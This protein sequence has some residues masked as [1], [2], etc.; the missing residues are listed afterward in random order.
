VDGIVGLGGAALLMAISEG[1]VLAGLEVSA[2]DGMDS[3]LPPLAGGGRGGSG[4][5]AHGRWVW[6]ED[7]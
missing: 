2:G 1:L 3:S 6:Q 5:Q 4:K 7:G